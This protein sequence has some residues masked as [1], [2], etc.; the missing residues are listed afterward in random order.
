MGMVW[1]QRR[2]QTL[3]TQVEK[4]QLAR[5]IARKLESNAQRQATEVAKT[6]KEHSRIA[7]AAGAAGIIHHPS[8]LLVFCGQTGVDISKCASQ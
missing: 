3:Q 7:A 6:A 2:R 5:V 1:R 8:T 4:K